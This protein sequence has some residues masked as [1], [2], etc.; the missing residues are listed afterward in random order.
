MVYI[1]QNMIMYYTKHNIF[2]LK[3]VM[4]TEIRYINMFYVISIT[5]I[6]TLL[7]FGVTSGHIFL[8]ATKNN[9]SIY[10]F[11]N[12]LIIIIL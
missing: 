2:A 7:P 6:N 5:N 3:Y 1:W 4:N 8:L 10:N 11:Y 12:L 9:V